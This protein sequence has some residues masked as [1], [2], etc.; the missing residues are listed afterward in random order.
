MS[1]TVKK[2]VAHGTIS[3]STSIVQSPSISLGSFDKTISDD[4]VIYGFS[5][6]VYLSTTSYSQANRTSVSGSTGGIAWTIPCNFNSSTASG[7]WYTHEESIKSGDDIDTIIAHRVYQSQFTSVQVSGDSVVFIK[8]GASPYNYAAGVA[9]Y[10]FT[11]ED[12]T[13]PQSLTFSSNNVAPKTDVYMTIG[14]YARGDY[15]VVRRFEI[16][17]SE[18]ENGTYTKIGESTSYQA[19]VTSHA[20]YGKS[21]WYKAKVVVV[22]WNGKERTSDLGTAFELKTKDRTAPTAPTTLK[23]DA[24]AMSSGVSTSAGIAN[25]EHTLSWSGA[26]AGEGNPVG[27]YEVWRAEAKDGTYTKL[28]SGLTGTS[29]TVKA[30]ATMGKEYWYRIKSVGKDDN[31]KIS[32]LS[33]VYARLQTLQVTVPTAPTAVTIDNKS[34][35][36]AKA[37]TQHTLRWSGAAHGQNNDITGYRV[38][39][40]ASKSSGYETLIDVASTVS[41][42][43][44][45][46]PTKENET[47]YYKIMTLGQYSN[48]ANS[49]ATASI[50]AYVLGQTTTPANLQLAADC[51]GP[52]VTTT[53]SWSKS[54]AGKNA[55]LS[56]YKIYR[57]TSPASG[58]ALL[59]TV[60]ANTTSIQV[61]SRN[62]EGTAYYYKVQA[63][64]T[65]SDADSAM[66]DW[67]ALKTNSSPSAPVISSG[68]VTRTPRP[69]ILITLGDDIEEETMTVSC[70]GCICSRTSGLVSG[71]TVA[72][73]RREPLPEGTTEIGITNA[74]P[75]AGESSTTIELTYEPIVW[76]DPEVIAGTTV[77]KAAHIAEMQQAVNDMEDYYQLTRTAWT[78]CIAGTTSTLLWN[79]HVQEI[80]DALQRLARAVNAWDPSSS[81]NNINLGSLSATLQPSAALIMQLRQAIENL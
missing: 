65:D 26:T 21:Y 5:V 35:L 34:D 57:S 18:T 3:S 13:A 44:V 20:T 47:V 11:P 22:D 81:T 28:S 79:T 72:A 54:T 48:S 40:S 78:A 31:T 9:L 61:T 45:T 60:D 39:I 67:V 58:Y 24:K 55:T 69:R 73:R 38:L 77:I 14:N 30:H 71:S 33:T 19:V 80:I 32:D 46:A 49:G 15:N 63:Y 74:D 1:V 66:S 43:T 56:G 27:S 41:S 37:G 25:S 50:T 51:V 6:D 2:T 59:Q 52:E 8:N 42:Y 62:L 23:I 76:T 70:D 68:I 64:C 29:T 16:Y 36:D 53:L 75:H 7:T 12:P 17:R 10:Y 4:D